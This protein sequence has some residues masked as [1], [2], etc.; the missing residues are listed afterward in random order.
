MRNISLANLET[1]FWVSRLGSFTAAAQRLYTT[2]PAVS[3]RMR[4]LESTLGIKLFVRNGRGVALTKPG[5]DF[6]AEAEPLLQQLER[7]TAS[8]QAGNSIAGTVRIGAGNIPMS[9]FPEIVNRL[10]ESMPDLTFDVDV[11]IAIKL[12]QRLDARTLD[13]AIVA[14]PV[15][16]TRHLVRSLGYDQMLWVTSPFHP[17][18][19]TMGS[20]QDFLSNTRLWCV[21]R[22]SFYWSDALRVVVDQGGN[23]NNFNAVSSMSAA[24]EI[25]LGC[26]G[27]GLLSATLIHE[28][29]EAGRLV[30][31]PGLMQNSWV[32]LSI[33]CPIQ[34]TPSRVVLE[35]M[36]TAQRV[37][38]LAREPVGG[39]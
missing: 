25:V 30:K 34:P 7:L 18:L 35:I 23:P 14:G 21:Q 20:L 4:E 3:A 28:D 12:L 37:S 24:R 36:D 33:V 17:S 13:L 8:F 1:A 32:E 2:Q 38:R 11:D 27:I 5:R 31:I 15:D 10:H 19:K 9:W 39:G 16:E 22:E 29:L 26:A 6:L